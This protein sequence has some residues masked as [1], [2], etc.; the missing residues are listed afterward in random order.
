MEISKGKLRITVYK[1]SMI[2]TLKHE[3]DV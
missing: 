2:F 1:S 3:L